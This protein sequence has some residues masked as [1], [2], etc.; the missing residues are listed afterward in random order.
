MSSDITRLTYWLQEEHGRIV[1]SIADGV[2]IL[3]LVDRIT[4]AG[5]TAD[6]LETLLGTED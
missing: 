1:T 3:T 6:L 5:K 2:P 4:E